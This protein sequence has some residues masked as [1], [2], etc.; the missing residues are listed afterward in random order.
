M[1]TDSKKIQHIWDEELINSWVH[2]YTILGTTFAFAKRVNPIMVKLRDARRITTWIALLKLK[3]CPCQIID[4]ELIYY[5][6]KNQVR[7]FIDQHSHELT[8]A[9]FSDN[10]DNNDIIDKIDNFKWSK[11]KISDRQW[12]KEIKLNSYINRTTKIIPLR[13]LSKNH[14]WNTVK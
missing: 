4:D 1:K 8:N 5:P 3:R 12:N 10:I 6:W 7:A 2:F 11:K 14:D 13:S 9:L